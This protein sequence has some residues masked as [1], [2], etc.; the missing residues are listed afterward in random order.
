MSSDQRP[1]KQ[2]TAYSFT[3]FI[4]AFIHSFVPQLV[5]KNLLCSGTELATGATRKIKHHPR[6]AGGENESEQGSYRQLEYVSK[7][8]YKYR[9]VQ[10]L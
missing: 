1:L 4:H 5:T 8:L 3:S 9:Q 10:L 7:V 2:K 6:G